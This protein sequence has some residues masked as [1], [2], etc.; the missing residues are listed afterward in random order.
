MSNKT[1]PSCNEQSPIHFFHGDVCIPC[2]SKSKNSKEAPRKEPDA[3]VY[4]EA[5]PECLSC[6]G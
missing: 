3:K 1:C 5:E 2:A 4:E 6:A